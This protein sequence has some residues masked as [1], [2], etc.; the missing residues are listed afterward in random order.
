MNAWPQTVRRLEL[1]RRSYGILKSNVRVGNV[2]FSSLCAFT[3]IAHGNEEEGLSGS[4]KRAGPVGPIA[5]FGSGS[6]GSVRS[7][8]FWTVFFEI[9]VKIL[10]SMSSTLI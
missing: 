10:V 8:Q 2:F 7:V 5:R 3:L 1:G 4:F 9:G 6:T